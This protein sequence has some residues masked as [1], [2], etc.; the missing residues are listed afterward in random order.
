MVFLFIKIQN[1]ALPKHKPNTT[2]TIET[3]SQDNKQAEYRELG[4]Q[5]D[6]YFFIYISF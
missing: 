3:V 6:L 5:L 1:N 2:D 4:A